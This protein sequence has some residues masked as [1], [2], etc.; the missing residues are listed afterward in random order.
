MLNKNATLTP[1]S[2]D[3]YDLRNFV[4]K[5]CCQNVRTFSADFFGLKNWIPQTLSFFG[6]MHSFHTRYLSL[7]IPGTVFLQIILSYLGLN[8]RPTHC[9]DVVIAFVSSSLLQCRTWSNFPPKL[10][11][12]SKTLEDKSAPHLPLHILEK[13]SKFG[14]KF[15]VWIAQTW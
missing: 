14:A 12:L 5:F 4:A 13:S 1:N 2:C 7:F 8:N 6:C 9:S 3:F 15:S 11:W 10:T